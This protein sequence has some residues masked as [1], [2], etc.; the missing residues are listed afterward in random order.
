MENKQYSMVWLNIFK[1]WFVKIIKLLVNKFPDS[2]YVYKI[3]SNDEI[4]LTIL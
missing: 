2:M 1:L 3:N 4:N